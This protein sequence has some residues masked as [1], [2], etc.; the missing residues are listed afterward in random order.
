[1]SHFELVYHTARSKIFG[2]KIQRLQFS[3][4]LKKIIGLFCKIK[5]IL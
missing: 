2:A 4:D 3:G 1:M 5:V